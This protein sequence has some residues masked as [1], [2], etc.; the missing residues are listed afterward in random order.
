M[1]LFC[2][3]FD[4]TVKALIM[5]SNSLDGHNFEI[6]IANDVEVVRGFP[7]YKTSCT[8]QD[9]GLITPTSRSTKDLPFGAHIL[10]RWL[11]DCQRNACWKWYETHKNTGCPKSC[12]LFSQVP[13]SLERYKI[14]ET[15]RS[16]V[17][18]YRMIHNKFKNVTSYFQGFTQKRLNNFSISWHENFS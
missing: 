15:V 1:T 8:E 2:P 4:L 3:N 17:E 7:K 12:H 10:K 5:N 14:K 6:K 13:W 16:T 11:F 18:L 9:S